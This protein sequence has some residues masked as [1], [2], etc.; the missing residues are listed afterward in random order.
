MTTAVSAATVG[1]G[2]TVTVAACG[3]S[4]T[5]PAMSFSLT[6][7]LSIE[8]ALL[9]RYAEVGPDGTL[10][11]V[12]GGISDISRHVEADIGLVL[13]VTV[14]VD[15]PAGGSQHQLRVLLRDAGGA[16]L[17][18]ASLELRA[19]GDGRRRL[20]MVLPIVFPAA[21]V[22]GGWE[23]SLLAEGDLRKLQVA[24]HDAPKP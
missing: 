16:R 17:F 14:L 10:T 7:A 22:A 12:G 19:T 15:S 8:T 23:L 3:P 18:E 5:V 4:T 21:G 6:S 11:V 9:A 1:A 13:A 24:V 2:R 20:P